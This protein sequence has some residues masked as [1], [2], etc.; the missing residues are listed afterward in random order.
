VAD[1]GEG[2][3]AELLG[4]VFERFYRVDRARTRADG[5]SGIELTIARA[6]VE[7]HG[8]HIRAERDGPGAGITLR[9]RRPSYQG[10]YK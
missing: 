1:T 5:D 9:D 7:A 8:G 3:P 4:R 10:E 6:I 2:I